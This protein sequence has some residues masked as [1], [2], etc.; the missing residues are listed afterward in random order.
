[1]YTHK[2]Q[3][4]LSVL[5]DLGQYIG[6]VFVDYLHR[7]LLSRQIF[8]EAAIKHV[9]GKLQIAIF[10]VYVTGHTLGA[11][12]MG[13]LR[14]AGLLYTNPFNIVSFR[15]LFTAELELAHLEV[16]LKLTIIFYLVFIEPWLGLDLFLNWLLL[17]IKLFLFRFLLILK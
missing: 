8:L 2:T 15:T 7:Y 16:L 10:V 11:A 6:V 3:Y 4:I 1:M 13:C 12:A 14:L 17:D 9:A 5:L